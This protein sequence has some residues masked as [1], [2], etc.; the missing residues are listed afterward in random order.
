MPS[1]NFTFVNKAARVMA[2][3]KVA[4]KQAFIHVVVVY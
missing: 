4:N 3:S 1:I 2:Q